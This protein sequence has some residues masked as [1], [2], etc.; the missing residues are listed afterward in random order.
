MIRKRTRSRRRRRRRRPLFAPHAAP[1][2]ELKDAEH[3]NLSFA[4]TSSGTWS[5]VSGHNLTPDNASIFGVNQGSARTTRTG[6]RIWVK[7]LSLRLGIRLI[8]D[9]VAAG[10]VTAAR[11][12]MEP[13]AVCILLCI[14]TQNNSSAVTPSPQA[15]LETA[16]TDALLMPVCLRELLESRRYRILRR[17]VVKFPANVS[18][19][20][21]GTNY[22]MFLPG[23]IAFISDDINMR[24]LSV[25]YNDGTT[26]AQN[27]IVTNHCFL[28]ANHTNS[29]SRTP[30]VAISYFSRIRF[31]EG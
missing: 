18:T 8:P 31:I 24:N 27:T 4:V 10:T 14:D 5:S 22:D 11:D 7:H 1:R 26:A 2:V 16:G 28:L 23:G 9:Y 3:S 30:G 12:G 6:R 19:V 20:H 15:V 21:N 17:Y 29:G 13:T 25:E